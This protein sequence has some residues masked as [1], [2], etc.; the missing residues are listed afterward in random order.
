MHREKSM[1]LEGP[2]L[3]RGKVSSSGYLGAVST[4]TNSSSVFWGIHNHFLPLKPENCKVSFGYLSNR[5]PLHSIVLNTSSSCELGISVK[6]T[7]L[8]MIDS[9]SHSL[10][11]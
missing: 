5:R 11:Q 8:K 3:G 4:H 9:K 6:Y 7:G 1:G 10:F 2:T